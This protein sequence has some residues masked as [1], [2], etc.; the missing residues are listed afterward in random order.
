M[1]RDLYEGHRAAQMLSTLMSVMAIAPLLG[2]SVG[3][4]ILNAGS[5]RLIFWALVV[6]GIGTLMLLPKLPETLPPIRRNLEPLTLAFK[7]YASLLRQRRVL[8]YA[9]T[10]GFFYGAMFAYIAGTPFAYITYY[11]VSPQ[12]YGLLFALGIIGIMV[13][14]QLNARWVARIGG[15]CLLRW[16]TALAALSAVILAIDTWTG[17][18]G[19]AGLVVPLF[20]FVGCAG[21]IIA[22]SI[23]GAL[24]EF[25]QYAGAV[26]ALIGSLQYGTGILGS[27]LVAALADATPRPMGLVIV[28]FA[29]GSLMCALFVIPRHRVERL[30]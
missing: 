25:P 27:G 6:V 30:Q 24:G 18:G 23:V 8:G 21:F 20:V 13:A 14:N 1:V 9:G 16:G 10:G 19:L 11:H 7:R 29:T 17:W 4:L 15:D 12:Q 26:S 2:P 28:V 5:W 22:N 3:G